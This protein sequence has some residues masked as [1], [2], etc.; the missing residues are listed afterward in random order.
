MSCKYQQLREKAYWLFQGA[1]NKQEIEILT[2]AVLL[3]CGANHQLAMY[4][5]DE[6]P[7]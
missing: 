7:S 6:F 4:E 1:P 5:V 2:F 3:Y